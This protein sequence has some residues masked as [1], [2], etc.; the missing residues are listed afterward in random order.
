MTRTCFA[1][2]AEVLQPIFCR[3]EGC[4]VVVNCHEESIKPVTK[5]GRAVQDEPKKCLQPVKNIS[6]DENS[7][8]GVTGAMR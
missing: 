1:N 5:G 8:Y 7:H 3:G 4:S 2:S 6:I